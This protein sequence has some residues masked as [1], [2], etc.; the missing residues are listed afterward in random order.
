MKTSTLI[1]G[2]AFLGA[3]FYSC[4]KED[5]PAPSQTGGSIATDQQLFAL[6]RTEQTVTPYALFPLAD[7]VV[8]GTLNG[9][10][11]HQPMVR[12]TLNRTALGALS[13][14]RLATGGSFPDGSVVHKE[15]RMNGQTTLFVVVYKD[16]SNPL[17]TGG[18]LWAEFNPAGSAAFSIGNRGNGCV[19]CHE[20]EQGPGHDR[21]RTFE[22][23]SP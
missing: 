14:G 22:R 16:R 7:S 11:A 13:N 6:V 17:A 5:P 10:S 23:Q 9:S 4:G 3:F 2:V 1:I 20:R 12:V 21:I 18:W 8:A 19:S 15:I